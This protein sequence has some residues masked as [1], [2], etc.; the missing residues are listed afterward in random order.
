MF[1]NNMLRI[2]HIVLVFGID[3]DNI[4]VEFNINVRYKI[5]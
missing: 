5:I 1:G 4:C 2:M 3:V